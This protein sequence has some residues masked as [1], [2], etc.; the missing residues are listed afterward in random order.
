LANVDEKDA[1]WLADASIHFRNYNSVVTKDKGSV[2]T[3]SK[4]RNAERSK[5]FP[6]GQDISDIIGQ[7]IDGY[8]DISKGPWIMELGA[9]PNVASTW[10]FLVKIGVHKRL[11]EIN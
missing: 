6:N 8:V 4:I 9:T 10:L 5:K 3:L 2:A 7:F 1:L 11:F